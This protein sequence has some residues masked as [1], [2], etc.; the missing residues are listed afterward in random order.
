[1]SKLSKI[2]VITAIIITFAAPA[3]LAGPNAATIQELFGDSSAYFEAGQIK[4][5]GMGVAP[6]NVS[7]EAQ[8]FV[9]ARE[10]AIV[11]ARA[12]MLE[13]IK[14]VHIDKDTTVVN[15]MANSKI[16]QQVSGM[17]NGTY[18]VEDSDKWVEG[19]YKVEMERDLLD[20][21]RIIYVEFQDEFATEEPARQ[22]EYTGLIVDAR[23][24]DLKPQVRFRI[25]DEDED[26]VYA[27]TKA[28]YQPAIDSG[29]VN[30]AH[31]V[32][33]AKEDSRMG[34]N[35]MVVQAIDTAGEND[36]VAVV[37]NSEG[38][39]IRSELNETEVFRETKVMVIIDE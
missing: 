11:D 26:V 21:Y 36:T 1:M 16:N 38:S 3:V 13:Y 33:Q 32:E 30:F 19:V 7:T 25:E 6:D 20:L 34:D 27:S 8:G 2:L 37:S 35:P 15:M 14:G 22:T 12:K 28:L 24:V 39:R 29:L 17:I 10:A 18:V 31:S 9:M 5:V 4:T 23:N